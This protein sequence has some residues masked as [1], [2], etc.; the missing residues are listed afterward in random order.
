MKQRAAFE[1][2]FPFVVQACRVCGFAVK[3]PTPLVDGYHKSMSGVGSAHPRLS[4]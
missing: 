4:N 3:P 2:P 1:P